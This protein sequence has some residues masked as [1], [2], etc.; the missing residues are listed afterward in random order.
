MALDGEAIADDGEEADD[1]VVEE[2]ATASVEHGRTAIDELVFWFP[3]LV[4]KEFAVLFC[5]MWLELVHV[6]VALSVKA[7]CFDNGSFV[8]IRINCSR[9][10]GGLRN[11]ESPAISARSTVLPTFATT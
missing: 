10:I 8:G 1:S 11:C 4:E 5:V 9:F 3:V 7:F 6:T 2:L